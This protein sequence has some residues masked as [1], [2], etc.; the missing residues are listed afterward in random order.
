VG[1]L[2]RNYR[3]NCWDPA[4][5]LIEMA[6]LLILFRKCLVLISVVGG[7]GGGGGGGDFS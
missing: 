1:T 3:R 6:T 2:I 4:N 5:K 7:G